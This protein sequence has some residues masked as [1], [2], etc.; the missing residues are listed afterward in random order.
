VLLACLGCSFREHIGG[1]APAC[2]D[3]SSKRLTEGSCW[4]HGPLRLGATSTWCTSQQ[5]LRYGSR[6][7]RLQHTPP[8]GA[9]CRL[10]ADPA[11]A[12]DRLRKLQHP[13]VV[14]KVYW[15]IHC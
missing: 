9:R 5:A 8:Q 2:A 14:R 13:A 3:V 6:R 12:V 10:V 15:E 7:A 11:L 1:M 4:A